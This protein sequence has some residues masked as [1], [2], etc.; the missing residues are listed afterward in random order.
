[1]LLRDVRDGK[2]VVLTAHAWIRLL[3]SDEVLGLVTGDEVSMGV[4]VQAYV[5][6]YKRQR[7]VDYQLV[8]PTSIQ[9]VVVKEC[10]K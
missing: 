9:K 10:Q 2:G 6:G 3:S 8:R 1:M 4:E 7:S 5:K